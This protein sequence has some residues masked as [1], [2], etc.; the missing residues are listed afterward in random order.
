M[1]KLD[2]FVSVGD[3]VKFRAA[4]REPDLVFLTKDNEARLYGELEEC[5]EDPG[6]AAGT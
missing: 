3:A 5:L 2:P 4:M 1:P 6:A